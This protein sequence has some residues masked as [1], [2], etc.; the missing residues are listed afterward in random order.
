MDSE[1]KIFLELAGLILL[2]FLTIFPEF[3]G[4]FKKNVITITKKKERSEAIDFVRGLAMTGIVMIHV[5]SYFQF[6]H[7]TDELI[8]F[9][10]SMANLSRYSVPVFI[11]S[12]GFF[13]SWKGVKEYWKPKVI[14]LIIPY[15]VIAIIGYFVKY[16]IQDGV[17][18]DLGYRLIVG[19]V[20][21]PYYYVSLLV[22][23]YIVYSLFFRKIQDWSPNQL[24]ALGVFATV[25]N[26]LSN[27][28]LMPISDIGRALENISFTNFIFF[29]VFGLITKKH[30]LDTDSY[31]SR[32]NSEPW[33]Y[34]LLGTLFTY[35]VLIVFVSIFYK[36]NLTNHFLFYP[37][38]MFFALY[39]IA[40][41]IEKREGKKIAV[42]F[43]GF[44]YIGRNSLA[45]FL[46]HPFLIHLMHSI[47]PYYLGGKWASWFIT[48][49][50]NLAIPLGIWAI[51]DKITSLVSSNE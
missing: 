24:L 1:I 48:I 4:L 21:E 50:L 25:L 22:Q 33:R 12:S 18:L 19:K 9:T 11:I 45:V 13:L 41:L 38:G 23:F 47:D 27:H 7:P 10:R 44:A 30:F 49:F 29:F 16:P 3:S 17:I 42:I 43:K 8:G 40:I 15:L 36:Y 32:M 39:W 37:L 5:D 35:S 14:Q 6:F 34:T 51:K 26:I 2:A 31:L 28:L 20:F 46:L